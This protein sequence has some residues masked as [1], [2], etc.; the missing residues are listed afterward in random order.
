M[1]FENET[2]EIPTT[3]IIIK[4]ELSGIGGKWIRDM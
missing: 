4:S 2:N 3:E 1:E